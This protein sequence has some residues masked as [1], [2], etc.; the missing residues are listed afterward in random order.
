MQKKYL[1]IDLN[2]NLPKVKKAIIVGK[3]NSEATISELELLLKTLGIE[4]IY[5]MQINIREIN[6]AYFIGKG[7]LEELKGIVSMLD[8]DMIVFDEE[9]SFTQLRNI[10]KA[11]KKEISDRP[12]I[13]LDIFAKRALSREGKIQ[14]ELAHLK[15]RLPELINQR[16]SLDQQVGIIGTRG[17]GERSIEMSRRKIMERI[18]KLEKN[19]KEIEKQ[20]NLKR[21]RRLESENFII[22]IVGYTNAGKSTLFNVLTKETLPTDD[23][24][25]HTLDTRIRKGF[26]SEEIREVLFVD[27]VGFIRKLP[28]ELIE[29][30]KSTL[31]EIK[32]SD[33]ILIVVDISDSNFKAQL[34]TVR[35][36]L[37]DLGADKIE[38]IIVYNKIDKFKPEFFLKDNEN[39]M[40][41]SALTQENIDKLKKEILNRIEKRIFA[42][43]VV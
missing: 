35:D 30:F 25:F 12:R 42:Q 14:V 17:P 22:S 9:L 26:I 8:A 39:G 27:T 24:L 40:F 16:A 32:T 41:V 1:E 18:R 4:T 20:R 23:L 13:I 5:K 6:P 28:H 38:T 10:G 37:K 7:K 34:K 29:S 36:T 3:R 21:E 11:L 15:L 43:N 19:L 33:L 2:N 31:E